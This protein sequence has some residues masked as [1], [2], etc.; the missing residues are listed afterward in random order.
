MSATLSIV[1][2]LAVGAIRLARALAGS[3]LPQQTTEADRVLRDQHGV[4]PWPVGELPECQQG[5]LVGNARALDRTLTAPLTG[6]ACLYYVVLVVQ[7]VASGW[8]ERITDRRGV[9]FELADASGSAVIDPAQ[10]SVALAF[11]HREELRALDQATAAQQEVLARHGD[12]GRGSSRLRFLEAVLSVGERVTV[13]G[14]GTRRPYV[15]RSAESDYRSAMPTRMHLE[16]ADA[17]PLSVS[18]HYL[19]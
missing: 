8:Q 14:S 18:S 9:A 7:P 4:P 3:P 6:R 15:G 17:A 16:G 12:R 13:V 10:A 5:R 2:V 19:R 11:D 1:A